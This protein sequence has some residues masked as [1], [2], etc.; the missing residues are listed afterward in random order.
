[1]KRIWLLAAVLLLLVTGCGVEVWQDTDDPVS[2]TQTEEAKEEQNAMDEI[3]SFTIDGVQIQLPVDY[4]T[5][6]GAGWTFSDSAK[7]EE[8]LEAGTYRLES[9]ELENEAYPQVILRAAFINQGKEAAPMTGC[10]VYGFAV[11]NAT[12][13]RI[14]DAYPDIE[15]AGG[16]H[17]GSNAG[18]VAAVYGD[19]KEK[20][21]GAF[22][23]SYFYQSGLTAMEF[24]IHETF[25]VDRIQLYHLPVGGRLVQ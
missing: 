23:T 20:I 18:E 6:A 10:Q 16:V 21:D 15:L 1:M 5:L 11:S 8:V 7:A 17:F 13:D 4:Q 12:Y 19:P 14:Y 24:G 9:I 22:D 2:E 25:G 3:R